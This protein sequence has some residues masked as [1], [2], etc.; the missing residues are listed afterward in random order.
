MHSKKRNKLTTQSPN[1]M[2][3]VFSNLTLMEKFKQPENLQSRW[4][5]QMKSNKRHR[6]PCVLMLMII[7]PAYEMQNAQDSDAEGMDEE[8]DAE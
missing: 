4:R 3:F 6:W 5:R 8:S 7:V 1:D 2:V